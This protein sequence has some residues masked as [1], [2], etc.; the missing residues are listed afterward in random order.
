MKFT[1]LNTMKI[2]SLDVNAYIVN[3]GKYMHKKVVTSGIKWLRVATDDSPIPT[4]SGA[5]RATFLS[6][7]TALGTTV[8]IGAQVSKKNRVSLGRLESRG[9][10][11]IDNG[12][13][14]YNFFYGTT[15]RYLAYNEYNRATA[16]LPP[17]PYSNM[18]RFTPYHFQKK[19]LAAWEKFAATVTLPNPYERKYLKV[20][21]A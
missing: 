2:V 19:A 21:K 17:Q 14:R 20:R 8:P 11:N 3:L 12:A 1:G 13:F 10:V 16:G 6:L 5:S 9:E 4:W 15:L 7:A 18:V